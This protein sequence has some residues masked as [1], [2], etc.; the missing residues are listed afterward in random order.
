L[1]IKTPTE[2][3]RAR[4]VLIITARADMGGGPRHV[5]D[6]LKCLNGSE[7]KAFVAAPGQEPFF[8]QFAPL[9]YGMIEIAARRFSP[10]SFWQMA[11][12]IRENKIDLIH[13][14]GRGAGLYSRLLGLLT[15][16]PVIHTFHGIHNEPS[17]A[18]RFKLALDQALAF[19]PFHA[20]FVAE[21]ERQAAV[22]E[23]VIHDQTFDVIHN[24][25]DLTRFEQ[26]TDRLSNRAA[27]SATTFRVGVFLRDDWVKGP[28]LFLQFAAAARATMP[29]QN[30][31]FTCAGLTRTQLEAI[32]AS[33]GAEHGVGQN[34]EAL[35]TVTE[36]SAWLQDLD[37]FISTSRAE[38]LP[39]G[40]LEA[41]AAK[42]PCLLSR[43]EGHQL[44]IDSKC[45]E[46]YS[47]GAAEE[48]LATL[49]KLKKN[50]EMHRALAERGRHMIET[51]FSLDVFHERILKTDR[52]FVS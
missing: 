49:E 13:S 12:Q 44:F 32:A 2:A 30:V 21:T 46:S 51:E 31:V 43:V 35:G 7:F 8:D 36:P 22:R 1:F 26:R 14:H 19:L 34:I 29:L 42:C 39:I 47:V 50:P 45:A 28:D 17:I 33:A 48:F 23:R 41:M 38:G 3:N 27:D 6:L 25:V 52:Y 24:A 15:S 10:L 37:L 5:L 16:K 18:G 11:K 9:S 4:H 20:V 40:V